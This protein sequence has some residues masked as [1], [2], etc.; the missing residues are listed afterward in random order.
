MNVSYVTQ[1]Q[2]THLVEL[3]SNYIIQYDVF[4][5]KKEKEKRKKEKKNNIFKFE[6][7]REIKGN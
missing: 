1:R 3:Y 7:K 4:N 6:T 2:Y 5:F